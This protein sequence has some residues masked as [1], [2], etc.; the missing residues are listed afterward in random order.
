MSGSTW[1]TGSTPYK[2]PGSPGP[3]TR[4]E[5]Q[6]GRLGAGWIK[7][8]NAKEAVQ[9]YPLAAGRGGVS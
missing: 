6:A 4:W 8:L 5:V 7:G 1:Q 2:I 9:L 3:G